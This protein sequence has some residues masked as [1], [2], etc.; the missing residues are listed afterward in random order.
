MGL[1]LI[2]V[3]KTQPR[4]SGVVC[5][6]HN[7]TVSMDRK[8]FDDYERTII[9]EI[10]QEGSWYLLCRTEAG[11]LTEKEAVLRRSARSGYMM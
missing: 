8:L 5:S 2:G 4:Y 10:F 6:I 1:L 11:P 9:V 7:K 3:V